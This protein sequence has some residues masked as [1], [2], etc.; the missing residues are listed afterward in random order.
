MVNATD[1]V[2]VY[3]H[4]GTSA[5]ISKQYIPKY[6]CT[7]TRNDTRGIHVVATSFNRKLTVTM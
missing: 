4:V 2:W 7:L 1:N 3:R 5:C 6:V